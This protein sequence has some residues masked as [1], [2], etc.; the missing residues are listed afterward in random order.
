MVIADSSVLIP[1]MRIGKLHLL[2][3]FFGEI[4]I[5]KDIYEEV[6]SGK[7]GASEFEKACSDWIKIKEIN[8]KEILNKI[9]FSEDIEKPDASIIQLAEMNKETI[10]SNDY[11]LILVAKTKNIKCWWLTTFLLNCLIKKIITKI[12][13]KSILLELINAGLRLNNQV[14]A[15]ILEEIEKL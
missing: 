2:K 15:A 1:L 8:N 7:S 10:L 5:T 3:D 13:A 6:K 14:Y 9:A 12:E 11:L 4:C